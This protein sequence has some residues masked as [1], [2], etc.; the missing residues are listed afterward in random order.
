LG[1]DSIYA[2]RLDSVFRAFLG[3]VVPAAAKA[4]AGI[5]WKNDYN[6]LENLRYLEG[7]MNPEKRLADSARADSL[8]NINSIDEK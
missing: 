5:A 8:R 6:E 3:D 4:G 7:L 2:I 1:H